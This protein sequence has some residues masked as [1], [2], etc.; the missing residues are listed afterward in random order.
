MPTASPMDPHIVAT[1]YQRSF[2]MMTSIPATSHTLRIGM[3]DFTAEGEKRQAR[4]DDCG[5]HLTNS[6]MILSVWPTGYWK[7]SMFLKPLAL[8]L[9]Y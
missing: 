8:P 3:A 6:K 9:S 2:V 4:T 1:P 7:T 5:R